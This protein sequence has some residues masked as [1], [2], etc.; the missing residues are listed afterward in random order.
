M[1]DK[2]SQGKLTEKHVLLKKIRTKNIFM[3]LGGINIKNRLLQF[4]KLR[5][6]RERLLIVFQFEIGTIEYSIAVIS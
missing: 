1:N 3:D 2:E 4:L 6:I 5:K